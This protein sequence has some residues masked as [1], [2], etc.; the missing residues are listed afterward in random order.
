MIRSFV[1]LKP[2]E[3]HARSIQEAEIGRIICDERPEQLKMDFA[4]WS[5]SAVMQLIADKFAIRLHVR[6][7]GKCLRR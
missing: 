3:E 6:S 1:Y 2:C 4:L 7:V 5:R